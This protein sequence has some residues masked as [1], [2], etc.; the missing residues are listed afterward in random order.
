MNSREQRDGH[1]PPEVEE[2]IL[3]T[4]VGWVA[5]PGLKGGIQ[6]DFEG[7]RRGPLEARLAT[8]LDASALRRAVER[9][10]GAVLCFERGEPSRPIIL[11]L[12]QEPTETPLLDELLDESEVASAELIANGKRIS[13][14]EVLGG[15]TDELVLRCG[16]ASL[17][18]RRNGQVL[19]R[20][21]NVQVDAGSV[22]RLRGGKTQI[23]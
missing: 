2:R 19:L 6:V 21:E 18:L 14:D 20:G 8:A 22:L 3:G 1:A 10:Q 5:G 11:G 23:N 12:V 13:L 15:A 4:L 9:R 17:V 7:N 16:K